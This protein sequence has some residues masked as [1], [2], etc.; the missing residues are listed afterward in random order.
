[1]EKRRTNKELAIHTR[2]T[3]MDGISKRI[4]PHNLSVK[5][6]FKVAAK[7]KERGREKHVWTV[8]N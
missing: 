4:N 2:W 6:M 8:Y 1:M 7:K 3:K 5:M